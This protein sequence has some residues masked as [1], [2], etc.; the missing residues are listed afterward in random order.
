MV[1]NEV[2]NSSSSAVQNMGGKDQCLEKPAKTM[3]LAKPSFSFASTTE[4]KTQSAW[5]A[6]IAAKNLVPMANIEGIEPNNTEANIKEGRFR[7]YE[8]KEGIS[9]VNYRFDLA[10]CTYAALLSYKNKG[11]RVFEVTSA[12][13]IKCDI[14]DDGTVKGRK[15]SSMII[16]ERTDATDDDVPFVNVNLKFESSL[17]SIITPDFTPSSLEGIFDVAITEGDSNTSSSLKFSVTDACSGTAITTLEDGDIV[18]TD[19]SDAAQSITW[20][21]YDAETG[22]YEVTGTGFANGYKIKL[23]GVVAKTEAS[24]ELPSPVVVANVA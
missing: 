15:L 24:Y 20:V 22:L 14:Q 5:D 13:E 9:G 2:C 8:L 17:Y 12:E 18:V 1:K 4:M 16:G 21:G 19:G 23:N 11:Y 7:D 6:A 3:F 10:I